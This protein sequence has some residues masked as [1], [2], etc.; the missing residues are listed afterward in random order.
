MVYQVL[1]NHFFAKIKKQETKQGKSEGFDSCDRPS[2]LTQIG[3]KSSIFQTMWR[4]NLMG[5]PSKNR[6]PLLYYIKLC[7]SFQI[8][9]WIQTG[10]TVR[11]RPRSHGSKNCRFWPNQNR[12]FFETCDLAIWHMTLKNNRAPLLCY[13]KLCPSFPSHWWV[14]SGVTVRN[15]LIWVKNDDI[16]R[17]VTLQFDG[18]PWKTI[19]HLFYT[20]SSSVHN[21]VAIGE[22]KLNLQSGNVP[23][24]SK[25]TIFLAGW[26][27]N[28][29]DELQKQ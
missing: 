22:F 3:L 4:W 25:L 20:A 2:I 15:C 6:A 17:R 12:Q 26:P 23:F 24:G 18:W 8:H 11:K 14:Q 10:V 21:F 7:A 5:D 9:Q 1:W 28:L 27:C 16:F 13:F 19:G 29:T